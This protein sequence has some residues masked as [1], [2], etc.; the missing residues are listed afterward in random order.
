MGHTEPRVFTPPLR[1]LTPETSMGFACIEFARSVLNITLYPWQEWLLIHALEMLPDGTFRFRTIVVLVARQ[2]GKSTLGQVLALFFLYVREV[3]L[4]LGTAQSLDIS[5]D[6]WRD[7]VDMASEIPELA[8]EIASVTRQLSRETLE[9]VGGQRYKVAAA[10]RRGGRGKSGDLVL[11]DELREHQNWQAWSAITKT[12][13][14][15]R[16]ALVWCMSN[17]GDATSTVLRHLRKQ[18]HKRLGDPDGINKEAEGM[19]SELEAANLGDEFLELM[20][21]QADSLGIFEWSAAPNRAIWDREGWAEANPTV[22][23]G[24]LTERNIAAAAATDPEGEF[25]TEVLCQW[26]DGHLEGPFPQGKW[27]RGSVTEAPKAGTPF[28]LGVDVS[29][30]RSRAHIASAYWRHD[31]CPQVSLE[32]SRYGADWVEQ[33]VQE[34]ARPDRPLRLALQERGAPVSTLLG[35][36]E[37]IPYVIV[38]RWGGAELG[39][40]TAL[41]FDLVRESSMGDD[42]RR[43]GLCHMPAPALDVAAGAAVPRVMTDGGVMWDRVRSPVDISPLVAATAALWLLHRPEARRSAYDSGAELVVLD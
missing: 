10:T 14:A 20:E 33:W 43:T 18:A 26:V 1:E 24:E 22:G 3:A 38:E 31:G 13:M 28:V 12:T 9:L 19:P 17:A 23:H 16:L 29:A 27:E 34:R 35:K 7:T 36:L 15:R 6:L 4:V 39:N 21:E 8:V 37:A 5:S 42:G 32:A 30:D 41:M 11:M 25:R 2:N 40:G